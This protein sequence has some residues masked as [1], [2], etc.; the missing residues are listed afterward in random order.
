MKFTTLA[1]LVAAATAVRTSDHENDHGTTCSHT[2]CAWDSVNKHVVVTHPLTN[3]IGA[4]YGD[5]AE[6][7][8]IYAHCGL[9]VGTTTCA[10][11]CHNDAAQLPAVVAGGQTHAMES[12][13][14]TKTYDQSTATNHAA[15]DMSHASTLANS[16]TGTYDQGIDQH[17]G[18]N[19]HTALHTGTNDLLR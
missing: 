11:L 4:G 2:T 15:T 9:A 19:D 16:V 7:N 13:T 6:E 10:C 1:V 18:M 3:G 14:Y 8:G 12:T 17:T 5:S